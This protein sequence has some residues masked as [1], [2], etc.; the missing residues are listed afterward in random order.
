MYGASL[1]KHEGCHHIGACFFSLNSIQAFS[2]GG[3]LK[4]ISRKA[5]DFASAS[6]LDLLADWPS[7]I[8]R[9]RTPTIAAIDGLAL[10]AG[11]ELAMQYFYT[12]MMCGKTMKSQAFAAGA[13]IKEMN[14]KSFSS[15][16]KCD[17]LGFWNNMKAIRKP[18]IAAVNGYALGGGCELAMMCYAI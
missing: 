1:T 8:R 14:S 3:D 16:Q 4:E 2:A 12:D 17:M 5:A 7:M 9:I 10:G 11:A 18:I 6:K 15:V 13:D